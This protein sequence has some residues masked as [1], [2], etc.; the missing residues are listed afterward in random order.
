MH[1]PDDGCGCG[2][3]T[4]EK[5]ALRG[6]DRPTGHAHRANYLEAGQP[7][8]FTSRRQAQDLPASV[9]WRRKVPPVLTPVKDQGACGSCW[10]FA[11]AE[12]IES[13]YAIEQGTLWSLSE[14][15]VASC[16]VPYAMPTRTLE[17]RLHL[18]I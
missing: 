8:V 7:P 14:Q 16:A 9:D 1:T 6:Y 11:T 4:A 3:T 17:K 18:K 15:Q 10:T 2:R 12:T 5:R 13:R